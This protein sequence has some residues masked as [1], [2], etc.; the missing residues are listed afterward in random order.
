MIEVNFCNA[1]RD[2][3]ASVDHVFVIFYYDIFPDGP[4]ILKRIRQ[5]VTSMQSISFRKNWMIKP[6]K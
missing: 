6:W 4:E 2:A 1:L 3:G 5:R